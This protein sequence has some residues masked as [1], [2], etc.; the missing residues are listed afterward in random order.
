MRVIRKFTYLALTAVILAG[1]GSGSSDDVPGP[2]STDGGGGTGGSSGGPGPI[3]D[4]T[5][6]ITSGTALMVSVTNI[7]I[8]SSDEVLDYT[9]SDRSTNAG[10]A[11]TLTE[12]DTT[13]GIEFTGT[14]ELGTALTDQTDIAS[15]GTAREYSGTDEDPFLKVVFAGSDSVLGEID[16]AAGGGLVVGYFHGGTAATNMPTTG[17]ASYVGVAQASGLQKNAGE[18]ADNSEIALIDGVATLSADFGAG[19]LSGTLDQF[20][21]EDDGSSAGVELNIAGAVIAGTGYS[22]GTITI[23]EAGTTTDIITG[24]TSRLNGG[25]YGDAAGET[26]GAFNLTGTLTDDAGG[27]D[28]AIIGGFQATKQ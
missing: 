16:Y 8:S 7:Q 14:M 23:K 2:G 13:G 19:T 27:G 11:I 5:T 3:A 22:G 1:C 4:G 10:N 12:T 18:S 26:A 20:E 28:I 15:T 21:N 17:S 6:V 24:I 9:I 25:F